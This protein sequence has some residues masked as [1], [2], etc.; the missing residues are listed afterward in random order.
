MD[1][2]WPNALLEKKSSDG[3]TVGSQSHIHAALDLHNDDCQP[4]LQHGVDIYLGCRGT[5]VE[6]VHD[7]NLMFRFFLYFVTTH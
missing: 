3:K 4:Q 5:M 2:L 7:H 6:Y 1:D